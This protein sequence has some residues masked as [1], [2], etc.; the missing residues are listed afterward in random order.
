MSKGKLQ[1]FAEMETVTKTDYMTE[2]EYEKELKKLETKTNLAFAISPV[3]GI[4]V[5]YSYFAIRATY[6]YRWALKS[7]LD[8]YI[9][10]SRLSFGVGVAF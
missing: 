1:K 2:A 4:C 9:G 5:K 10:K 3:I 8:N 7:Q 6:Q